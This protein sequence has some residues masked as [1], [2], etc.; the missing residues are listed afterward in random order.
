VIL[1]GLALVARRRE[2]SRASTVDG[3]WPPFWLL[4][5]GL[6]VVMAVG[7]A[8]DIGS[9]VGDLARG[10]AVDSGW[11]E[12]RRPLQAVVVVLLGL[13]WFVT[14]SMACWRTW[15]R[16]RRYLP[17]GLVVVTLAAF[18]AIRVVSLHQVDALLH[19]REISGARVGTVIEMTLLVVAGLT[20]WW[21]PPARKGADENPRSSSDPA[22]S[23]R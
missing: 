20:T 11:Y 13:G 7:R 12:S 3:V 6:L 18:A 15:D 14:V 1:V 19:R 2:R 17:M 4:T 22:P 9:L 23:G 21:V 5:A 16:R 8:G 10:R